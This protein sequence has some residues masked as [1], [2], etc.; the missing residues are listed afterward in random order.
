MLFICF[1]DVPFKIMTSLVA[2]S[3]GQSGNGGHLGAAATA[4]IEGSCS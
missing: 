1:P 4:G 2:L 3:Y